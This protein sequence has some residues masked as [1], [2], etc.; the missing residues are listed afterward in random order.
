MLKC[1]LLESFRFSPQQKGR[2]HA[3][4]SN[5]HIAKGIISIVRKG[6]H[7]AQ[8]QIDQA[9][10][11]FKKI[12]Q[13]GSGISEEVEAVG[14]HLL[15]VFDESDDEEEDQI[16]SSPIDITTKACT[17]GN[18]HK[19][20]EDIYVLEKTE[21]DVELLLL[22]KEIS[23]TCHEGENNT[24]ACTFSS[25]IL[26]CYFVESDY[27][28]YHLYCR[29]GELVS[30]LYEGMLEGDRV[31]SFFSDAVPQFTASAI[32]VATLLLECNL[33]CSIAFETEVFLEHSDD[34]KLL[35]FQLERLVS[36]KKRYAV[37]YTYAGVASIFLLDGNTILFI[38]NH[39]NA[40]DSVQ[41]GTILIRAKESLFAF[42]REVA[43]VRN[44]Y[45]NRKGD[46]AVVTC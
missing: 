39:A 33:R 22:S 18:R 7:F 46:I 34:E 45:P 24:S 26:A 41:E 32:E 11:K 4:A 30:Q 42:I 6:K 5:T 15:E 12:F 40:V 31:Y 43:T 13:H 14:Q 16:G 29:M 19:F 28:I 9:A 8:S 10:M 1:Y 37:V 23:S 17:A 27:R 20:S 36:L 44:I 35:L 25:M 21:D 2:Y 3:N 38:D